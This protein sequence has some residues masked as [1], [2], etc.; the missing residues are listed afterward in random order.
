MART[1]ADVIGVRETLRELRKVEPEIY[2]QTIREIK[3]AA[4][5]LQAEAQSRI[6]SD[7]PLSGMAHKGRTGWSRRNA[8]VGVNTGGRA[9]KTSRGSE[10]TLVKIRLNG[11]AGGIFDMGGRASAGSTPQGK[12]LIAVLTSR[13]GSASRAMWPAA[14][15]K[16][17]DVQEQVKDAIR[18]ASAVMNRRLAEN[19]GGWI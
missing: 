4:K 1:N 18:K 5:P 17:P 3:Q 19:T 14:E 8:R 2:K 11:A 10:W 7:P 16:L 13:D 6:P 9:K 15:A 12:N